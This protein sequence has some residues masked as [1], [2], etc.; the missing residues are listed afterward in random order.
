MSTAPFTQGQKCAPAARRQLSFL[1]RILTLWI[2]LAMAIGAAIGHF[3]PSSA[4]FVNHFQR[5]T[6]NIP[7][8]LGLIIMMFPPLAKVP[9]RAA[10]VVGL[11]GIADKGYDWAGILASVESPESDRHQP[12]RTAPETAAQ[13]LVASAI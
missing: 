8:A 10:E 9:G 13:L 2:F 5:G 6:T 4:G 3:V 11:E 1:D 7:I 12:T